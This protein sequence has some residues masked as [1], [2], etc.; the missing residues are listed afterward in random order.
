MRIAVLGRTRWLL[1]A[2]QALMAVGHDIV[3]VATARSEPFYRCEPEDFSR[4]ASVAGAENFGVV[5]LS[6]T[7]VRERLRAIGAELAVSINWP[8]IVGADVIGLFPRGVVNAHCGDLPRYRGNA[9]P[10]WAILN[11][12]QRVGLCAHLMEPDMVDAGAVILR[13]YFAVSAD[14][15]IGDV[16]AWLD[17][18]VP[19]LLVEA[20]EGLGAGHLVPQPQP[21]DPSVTLR[22]YPRRPEDG[23][24]DWSADVARVH[25]LIR[26]SSRPF[27]G[28]FSHLD[29]GRR[30]TVWR[31]SPFAH[32][33]PFFAV[34][35]HVMLR[36]GSDPVI[37]CGGGA[38]RMEEL[39]IEGLD[40]D[41]AKVV[42]G[43]S[44]RGRL[45]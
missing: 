25:R 20:I 3:A 11:D 15:Y 36:A 35:G 41:E 34:P 13:D 10:N 22:C 26:A 28:A 40:A 21:T 33:V 19:T 8:T 5:S 23:R 43:R 30:V 17:R 44:L 16:Y 9:C 12:E 2:A 38:L 4:L 27:E 39:E 14:T 7:P 37:A 18:R 1:D 24:I 6:D 45:S 32:D 29:D 42:V 31:A